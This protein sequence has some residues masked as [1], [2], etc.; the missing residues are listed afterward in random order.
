MNRE[1]NSYDEELSVNIC[2]PSFTLKGDDVLL[3]RA[4]LRAMQR[5]A[6]A[7]RVKAGRMNDQQGVDLAVVKT[8][9]ATKLL[10]KLYELT[11]GQGE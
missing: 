5:E 1:I 7:E 11:M 8:I 2:E 3:V 6:H 10:D 4:A 9:R